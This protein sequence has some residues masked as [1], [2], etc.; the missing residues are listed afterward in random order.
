MPSAPADPALYEAL[1]TYKAT[2]HLPAAD[3]ARC[4]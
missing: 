1:R 4:A 3:F 2:R